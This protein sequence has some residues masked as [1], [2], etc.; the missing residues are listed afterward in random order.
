MDVL[1]TEYYVMTYTEEAEIGIVAT[2]NSTD[3]TV[4]LPNNQHGSLSVSYLGNIYT[5]GDTFTFTL[6]RQASFVY[7]VVIFMIKLMNV[8]NDILVD[9]IPE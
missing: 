8:S 4:T 3:V 6:N 2:E 9:A 1:G 7:V 5:N